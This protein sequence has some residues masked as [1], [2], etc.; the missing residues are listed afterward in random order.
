MGAAS[1]APLKKEPQKPR[2]ALRVAK[3][4]DSHYSLTS[5]GGVGIIPV[6]RVTATTAP[7]SLT[8]A[9]ASEP[10]LPPM[11]EEGVAPL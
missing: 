7:L 4:D 6:H 8:E 1:V 10:V 9:P 3:A 11:I 5:K 2:F